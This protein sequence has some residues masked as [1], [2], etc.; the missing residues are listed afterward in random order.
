MSSNWFGEDG[1]NGTCTVTNGAPSVTF[2]GANLLTNKAAAAGDGF[3]GPDGKSYGIAA[4][5]GE[6]ALTLNKNYAGT[7]AS[8]QPYAIQP[9]LGGRSVALGQ[10]VAT[11]LNSSSYSQI[12]GLSPA[13]GDFIQFVAG[14]PNTWQNRTVLQTLVALLNGATETNVASANNCDIGAQ[15]TPRLSITGTTQINTFNPASG[16]MTPNAIR[17]VRFAGILTLK[18]GSNLILP[19]AADIVTQAGDTACFMSDAAGTPVWR[20]MSYL[21]AD[22]RM[23]NMASPIFTGVTDIKTGTN[24]HFRFKDLS[25]VAFVSVSNDADNA[26]VAARMD[27]AS[28]LISGGTTF[29]ESASGRSVTLNSTN[30][31]GPYMRID[32][33]GTPIMDVGSAKN[34]VS[35]G[36]LTDGAISVRGANSLLLQTNGAVGVALASDQSVL[37]GTTTPG[38]VFGDAKCEIRSASGTG[39]CAHSTGYGWA[40][41]TRVDTLTAGSGYLQRFMYGTISVGAVTTDGTGSAYGTTS[42]GGL[43][44]NEQPYD[45]QEAVSFVKAVTIKEGDWIGKPGK[46]WRGVIAQELAAL[47]PEYVSAGSED[48]QPWQEGYQPHLVDYSKLVPD[49][50][51]VA[52]Y[53]IDHVEALTARAESSEAAIAALT[54]RLDTANL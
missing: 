37:I 53:L 14:S 47:R 52:Q 6:N 40:Q 18:N 35:G 32:A 2:S 21:R 34:I 17:F 48:L 54:A 28:W 12:A 25:G 4:V 41:T 36:N 24:E 26:N 9:L 1:T 8:S 45:L 22:G 3:V 31:N 23:V 27:A 5:T 11:L 19:G 51:A 7:T 42:D 50:M 30:A 44:F 16:T 15:S 29:S 33:S 10:L 39:F 38:G 13:V 43:K 46:R 49:L 20:C